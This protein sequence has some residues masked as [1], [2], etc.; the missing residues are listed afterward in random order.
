[1]ARVL[2]KGRLYPEELY[3][4]PTYISWNSMKTRCTSK[5]N[6]KFIA[7]YQERG[8]TFDLRWSLFSN[9]LKD[10]GLRP[11]G[12]TL[13]RIDNSKG[14]YKNNCR[15][16]TI[17]E[18][19]CNRRTHSNTGIKFLT[20]WDGLYIVS[21]RPFKHYRFKNLDEAKEHRDYLLSIRNNNIKYKRGTMVVDQI[22]YTKRHNEGQFNYSE[23]TVTAYLEEG[24]DVLECYKSLKN[25]VNAALEGNTYSE[26]TGKNVEITP[27]EPKKEEKKPRAK[28][29]KE[30]PKLE[31]FETNTEV[32][33]PVIEDVL[34]GIPDVIAEEKPKAKKSKVVS[35][36]PTIPEHKSS[37]SSYLNKTFGDSW[38]TVKPA[39]EIR[40]FTAGLKGLDFVEEDGSICGSFK[41]KLF[42]FFGK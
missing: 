10:M 21:V 39:D 38:K 16:S 33:P 5:A 9:F 27:E 32:I 22:V 37:L 14:Y 28:K 36:D 7:N 40:S 1:M 19:N 18:Q 30:E 12:T 20:L 6:K 23:Y 42:N 35:Y 11:P 15:W 34:P 13:D 2:E 4:S 41:N 24:D 17:S 25:S 8:I 26:P 31:A 29:A 3:Q